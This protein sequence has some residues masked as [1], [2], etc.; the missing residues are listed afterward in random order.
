MKVIISGAG[1]LMGKLLLKA[2]IEEE[3]MTL[4]GA[5][6]KKSHPF[7]NRDVGEITG[8][9]KSNILL[10]DD[11]QKVISAGNILVEFSSPPAVLSHLPIAVEKNSAVVIGTTGFS[12]EEKERIKEF[13]SKIPV[14]LSPNMSIGVNTLFKIA[15]ETAKILGTE[16]DVEIVECHHRRKKDAPSGTALRL[17]EI[18]EKTLSRSIK[19]SEQSLKGET[20]V[21]GRHGITAERAEGEIGIHAVRGGTVSGE[22]TVIF[23]GDSERVELTHRAEN[24]SVFVKGTIKAI[25]FA[26]GAGP[27]LYDMQDVIK[28]KQQ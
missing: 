21:Y 11:L 20:A 26:A 19:E 8:S 27:G 12:D 28:F 2:V 14:L 17:A 1:G 6:E 5:V 4:A 24:R 15:G 3:D 22:H 23:A 7:V 16:Y 10:T 9:A 18:I 13:S 25:R